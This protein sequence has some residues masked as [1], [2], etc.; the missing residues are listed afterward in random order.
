M[1]EYYYSDGQNQLGPFS[2]EIL[3]E[4]K[5]SKDTM[6][7]CEG[8]VDWEKAGEL[9]E[10]KFLFLVTP[11]PIKKNT[12][13][14]LQKTENPATPPVE[15]IKKPKSKK[16]RNIIIIIISLAIIVVGSI[17]LVNYYNSNSDDDSSSSSSSSNS[18]S[19]SVSSDN[20]QEQ[21]QSRPKTEAEMKADL[22]QTEESDPTKYLTVTGQWKLNL[23]NST[24]IEGD[25][26]N[27]A[28]LATFKDLKLKVTFKSKTGTTL[29][30]DN[31]VIY[32]YAYPGRSLHFKQKFLYYYEN[33]KSLSIDVV[34]ATVAK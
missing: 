20:S 13:P 26:H 14:P 12:P 7:W 25:I 29:G 1:K 24:V 17:L 18:S 22:R 8:M 32:D 2:L 31:F 27:S 33:G 9:E 28:T 34:S 19:N 6:V 10:L 11:P 4:K 3:K 5:I 21:Q 16:T 23:V 15:E 30:T